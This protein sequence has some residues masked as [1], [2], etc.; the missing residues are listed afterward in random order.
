VVEVNNETFVFLDLH[1]GRQRR[2]PFNTSQQLLDIPDDVWSPSK[3]KLPP[4]P[5]PPPPEMPISQE[6]AAAQ[7]IDGKLLLKKTKPRRT[8]DYFGPM[9]RWLYVCQ[10]PLCSLSKLLIPI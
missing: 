8:V 4:E 3:H 7:G 1:H 2:D 6:M 5:P 9:G 10:N